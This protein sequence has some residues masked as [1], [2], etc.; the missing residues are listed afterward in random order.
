MIKNIYDNKWRYVSFDM[1]FDA[2]V[3][4]RW[5]EGEG[6]DSRGINFVLAHPELFDK[7]GGVQKINA[8]SMVTFLN[9]ISGLKDFSDTKTLALIM[10]IAKGCFTTEDNVV[11]RLFTLFVANKLDKLVTPENMVNMT[12]DK[13]EK[14][15]LDCIYDGDNYRADIASI[16]S[17]RFI[18]YTQILFEKKDGKTDPVVNRI[19]ELIDEKNEKMLLSEDLIFNLIKTISTKYPQRTKKLITNPKSV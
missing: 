12:W 9:T 1:E 14:E 7:Q 18:N 10:D 17:T 19:L 13:L 15:L 16:L 2:A 8:R 3:W 4:A 5:A 6:I 11:G